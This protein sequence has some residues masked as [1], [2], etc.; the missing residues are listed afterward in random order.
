MSKKKRN[1]LYFVLVM[2]LWIL[3]LGCK[4]KELPSIIYP[5]TVYPISYYPIN[6]TSEDLKVAVVPFEAGK[7]LYDD[8]KRA[9]VEG[10]KE[11]AI[12]VLEA[13]IFPIRLIL[14]NHTPSEIVI[15][16]EQIT[17]YAGNL[18]Y[19]GYS[20]QEAVELVV[21]SAVFKKAIKGSHVG[22]LVKSILGGEIIIGAAQQGVGGVASGGVSGGVSGAGKGAANVGLKKA[23]AFEKGLVHLISKEYDRKRLKRQTLYPGFTADGLIF[24]P[25]NAGITELRIQAYDFS[26]KK[27]LSLQIKIK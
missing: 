1:S 10:D 6:T 9:A 14:E 21:N 25:S 27:L 26:L 16:P 23:F 24:L 7:N 15:D 3:P 2:V 8:P 20:P 17:G 12:D 11:E 13:G 18:S 5:K 22:P 4:I 19:R